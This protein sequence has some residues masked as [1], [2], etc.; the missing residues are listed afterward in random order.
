VKITAT[1]GRLRLLDIARREGWQPDG[2][3]PPSS[4][5]GWWD[6]ALAAWHAH[7]LNR[8]CWLAEVRQRLGL[9]TCDG[10]VPLTPPGEPPA[11]PEPVR[12]WLDGYWRWGMTAPSRYPFA[13]VAGICP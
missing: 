4:G 1:A 2:Y 11:G 12:S 3:P 13:L 8:D 9:V 7:Y 6:D 5:I 10:G